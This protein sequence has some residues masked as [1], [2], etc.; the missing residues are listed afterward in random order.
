M[1]CFKNCSEL[2]S[3]VSCVKLCLGCITD[4]PLSL[5]LAFGFLKTNLSKKR[6]SAKS[7]SGSPLYAIFAFAATDEQKETTC[8]QMPW[9]TSTH[10]NGHKHGD[11]ERHIHSGVS[12]VP[13]LGTQARAHSQRVFHTTVQTNHDQLH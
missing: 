4:P 1:S 8:S 10:G 2:T 11:E 13:T 7:R 6:A 12:H 9:R 3:V 5:A